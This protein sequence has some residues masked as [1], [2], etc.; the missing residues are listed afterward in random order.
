MV[1][2]A[3]VTMPTERISG[4]ITGS[5][6]KAAWVRAAPWVQSM[7]GCATT[8]LTSTRPVSAHTTTVSQK[9]PVDETS[10]CRTG[11]RVLAA[12]ATIG[13]EPRPDSLEKRPRAIPYRQAS[14]TVEPTNPPP[15]A[16]AVK[17]PET[18]SRRASPRWLQ[19]IPRRMRQP[20]T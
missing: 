19:F 9:V 8:L 17:A 5:L 4:P 7:S 3:K 2:N 6:E 15:T 14:R 16:L 10:A 20:I 13:A 12:A 1:E 11:L 18:I